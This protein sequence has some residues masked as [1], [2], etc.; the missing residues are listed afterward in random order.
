MW[1][2]LLLWFC[3][4]ANR[5]EDVNILSAYLMVTYA[6]RGLMH[7]CSHSRVNHLFCGQA[8][9]PLQFSPVDTRRSG[10]TVKWK[11]FVFVFTCSS[12]L[13]SIYWL[14]IAFVLAGPPIFYKDTL[15]KLIPFQSASLCPLPGFN[16][17]ST[18]CIHCKK[19]MNIQGWWDVYNVLD[20]RTLENVRK[21]AGHPR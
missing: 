5:V 15:S 11:F 1:W 7:I 2:Q 10:R 8:R 17:S 3:F 12:H 13:Q 4:V 16:Q 19:R 21:L 20:Y 6:L 14:T 9:T 18:C